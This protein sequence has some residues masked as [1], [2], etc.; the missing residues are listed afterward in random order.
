MGDEILQILCVLGFLLVAVTVIGHGIWVA[1]AAAFR[2]VTGTTSAAATTAGKPCPK[3]GARSSVHAG[4]CVACG[5][6]PEVTPGE[7]QRE[8][9]RSTARQLWRMLEQ[10][11]ITQQQYDELM[12]HIRADL[13]RHGIAPP[14]P[15]S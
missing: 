5:A 6:V 11:R 4:R 8:D 12:F 3:C 1:V 14:T 10:G 9:L 7:S 2:A 15:A 13:A